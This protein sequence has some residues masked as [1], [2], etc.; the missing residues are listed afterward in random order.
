M[1]QATTALI[2]LL[3]VA[4]ALCANVNAT[5]SKVNSIGPCSTYEREKL[6]EG[7][8]TCMYKDPVGIPTIGVGF[9]LQKS[10]ARAQIQGVGADYDKVLVGTECLNDG[11]IRT[12]FN[13]DI[14]TALSCA[15]SYVGSNFSRLTSS[16]G[17]AIV[18]MA[19]NLGCPRLG[20]F[21]NLQAALQSSPPNI[22]N[23]IAEMKDSAWCVQVKTR[24]T[25]DVACMNS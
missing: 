18:D 9:N 12:L 13:Q 24:C 6:N 8:F 17:S 20:G 7:Y 10:G 4:S 3:F 19:F 16:Q 22:A 11:Q 2:G 1:I 5:I 23:A 21:K 15:K 25:R 14:A